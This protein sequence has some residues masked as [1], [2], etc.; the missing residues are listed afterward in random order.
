MTERDYN[1]ISLRWAK[2][3]MSNVRKSNSRKIWSYV[4]KF[5]VEEWPF[6]AALRSFRIMRFSAGG[7]ILRSFG[8]AQDFAT[9]GSDAVL[10]AQL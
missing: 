10:S 8:F 4:L 3:I 5:L 9:A 2:N 1:F 6:R 7:Y